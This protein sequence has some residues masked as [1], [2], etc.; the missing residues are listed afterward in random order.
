[1][2]RSYTIEWRIGR[3]V[4]QIT[5]TN[6]EHRCRGVQSAELDGV[7]V[8]PSGIPLQD[9]DETHD[10]A[11]VLGKP[12]AVASVPTLQTSARSET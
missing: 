9:D 6:P 11:V 8:D 2:W 5:V 1:M 12:R 10:V 3:T 7:P 4:Y